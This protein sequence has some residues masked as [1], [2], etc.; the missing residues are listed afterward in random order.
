MDRF[1]NFRSAFNLFDQDGDGT[2]D[3]DELNTLLRTLGQRPTQQ[4]VQELFQVI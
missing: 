3:F 2:I 1:Q 4:E